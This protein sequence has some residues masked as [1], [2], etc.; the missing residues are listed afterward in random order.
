MIGTCCRVTALTV[1][2]VAP[3]RRTIALS[4]WPLDTS[5]I[6]NPCDRQGHDEHGDDHGDAAGGH[7]RGPLADQHRAQVVTAYETHTFSAISREPSAMSGDPPQRVDDL[8]PRRHHRRNQRREDA[9]E[10]AQS[11][12]DDGVQVADA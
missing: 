11:E 2:D 12:T 8:Q 5:V 6:W 4:T 10:R 1:S 9:D 3:L 7:R